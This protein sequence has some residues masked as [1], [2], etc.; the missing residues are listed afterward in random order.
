LPTLIAPAR[1]CLVHVS[2]SI[3]VGLTEATS[4]SSLRDGAAVC[5]SHAALKST[6]NSNLFQRLA[7]PSS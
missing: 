5:A 7:M 6:V 3:A 2:L 4:N 1:A